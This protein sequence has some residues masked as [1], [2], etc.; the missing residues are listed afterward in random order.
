MPSPTDPRPQPRVDGAPAPDA[1]DEYYIYQTLVG[2]FPPGSPSDEEAAQ[3]ESR[4]Q[5]AIEKSIREA[6]R[7]TSWINPD[8]AYEAATRTFVSRLLDR[9]GPFLARLQQFVSRVTLPGFMNALSQLSVKATAPG[10][11]DFFQGTELWDFSML[12]PDNRRPVD[13]VAR[14]RLL[15]DLQRSIGT[16]NRVDELWK[17]PEDGRIKLL[18][19]HAL[20]ALRRRHARLFERGSYEPLEVEG[21]RAENVIAFA[22]ELEGVVSITIA[23]RLFTQVVAGSP[24]VAQ[25]GWGSTSV[26]I[27]SGWRVAE[28]QDAV[29]GTAFK[30]T[31]ETL[32]VA[33]ALGRM[34]FAVLA[35]ERRSE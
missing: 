17:T 23:G 11:P 26:G 18:A 22:R 15:S 3:F 19:T 20:L 29:T 21:S 33:G 35:G 8:A 24:G 28:L 10:V 12:D 2:A 6:K 13:F 4:V 9:R 34:P 16:A 30:P 25:K 32:D 31:G 14:A 5:G 7:N 1:D 27:P